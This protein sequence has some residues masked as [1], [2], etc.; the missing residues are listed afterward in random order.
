MT[1]PGFRLIVTGRF[2]V[3][4]A[5]SG[6]RDRRFGLALRTAPGSE[7]LRRDRNPGPPTLD[8]FALEELDA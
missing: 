6:G 2:G 3:V 8:G 7:V 4:T 5:H 1:A